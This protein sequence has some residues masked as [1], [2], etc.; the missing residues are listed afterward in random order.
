MRA[1]NGAWHKSFLLGRFEACVSQIRAGSYLVRGKNDGSGSEHGSPFE[2]E[3]LVARRS[4][5]IEP[6]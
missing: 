1:L 4:K 3:L 2:R 5:A 6:E